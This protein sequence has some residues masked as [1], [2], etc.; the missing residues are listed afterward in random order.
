MG[1]GVVLI[2]ILILSIKFLK[3]LKKSETENIMFEKGCFEWYMAQ[4][5]DFFKS[6]TQAIQHA[7]NNNL[8]KIK[9]MYPHM[10]DAFKE[11][12]WNKVPVSLHPIIATPD[13]K[14]KI[15][16]NADTCKRGSFYWYKYMSGALVTGLANTIENSDHDNIIMIEK[17]YPQMIAAFRMH[18]WNSAPIGFVKDEYDAKID[19]SGSP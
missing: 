14:R 15:K 6:L 16:Y 8:N 3:F 9:S 12:N 19:K 11:P 1:I 7:D 2:I 4:Q 5:S 17:A 18:H 13:T 10:V